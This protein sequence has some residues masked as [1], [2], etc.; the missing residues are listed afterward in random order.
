MP[1]TATRCQIQLVVPRGIASSEVNEPESVLEHLWHCTIFTL[2]CIN[3]CNMR[4]CH[5]SLGSLHT[6]NLWDGQG[7][8]INLWEPRLLQL[9]AAAYTFRG[10]AVHA[11]CH[12]IPA[13]IWPMRAARGNRRRNWW[14]PGPKLLGRGEVQEA[15]ENGIWHVLPII[16]HRIAEIL[17][18][19][20]M[21]NAKLN[22]WV[23]SSDL[24]RMHFQH[25]KARKAIWILNSRFS[26][27]AL[28]ISGSKHQKPSVQPGSLRMDGRRFTKHLGF[29]NCDVL[30]QWRNS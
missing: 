20:T 30:S 8:S 5:T 11:L 19:Q 29:A 16:S 3:L 15:T 10:R 18:H 17:L 14:G 6:S 1:R 23:M 9:R 4:P 27:L 13:A 28:G 7:P 24:I 12:V 25:R 2:T 21:P 22:H 26:L